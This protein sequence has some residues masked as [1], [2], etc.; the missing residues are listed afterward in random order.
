[1]AHEFVDFDVR[2]HSS[3]RYYY[4][5]VIVRKPAKKPSRAHRDAALSVTESPE[6]REVGSNLL[7]LR[8]AALRKSLSPVAR[9]RGFRATVQ[10]YAKL[11][12]TTVTETSIGNGR[13]A[14]AR[15]IASFSDHDD[16]MNDINKMEETNLELCREELAVRNQE[17]QA[18]CE[19]IKKMNEIELGLRREELALLKQEIESRR[20]N[21]KVEGE[22]NLELRREELEL[23]KL[24][25]ELRRK[26]VQNIE[27]TNL[28]LR[29]EELELRNLDIEM[30]ME[31]RREKLE[32]WKL[33]I[34][35]RREQAA[36]MK[37]MLQLLI[38]SL[39]SRK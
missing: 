12:S 23:R 24:K 5:V 30:R 18:R 22:A 33:E 39:P 15:S 9:L 28:E 6:L 20:E 37:L 26:D 8:R 27:D 32:L 13:V 31:F 36:N 21:K 11:C 35:L 3:Q 16:L 19:D 34:E 7:Y 10:E 29:R 38:Q 1:M 14:D 17:T 2:F 25:I 4:M